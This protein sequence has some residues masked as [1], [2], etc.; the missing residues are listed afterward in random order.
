MIVTDSGR[1]DGGRSN[2]HDLISGYEM[3]DELMINSGLH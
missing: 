1:N 3:N 2:D